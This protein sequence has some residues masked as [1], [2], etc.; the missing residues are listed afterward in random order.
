MKTTGSLESLAL[1]LDC[2]RIGTSQCVE[3]DKVERSFRLGVVNQHP[4]I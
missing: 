2:A 3:I 1:R 4:A